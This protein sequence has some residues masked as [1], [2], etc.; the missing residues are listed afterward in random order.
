MKVIAVTCGGASPNRKL[1]RMHWH[2]IQDNDMNPET[3]VLI[4][5]VIYLAVSKTDSFTLFLMFHSHLLKTA[6][7]CL[8]SSRSGKFTCYTWNGSMFL[9]WNHIADILY[10][11][12]EC[13]LHILQNYA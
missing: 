9:L 8:S 12:Q 11:D 10:E 13:G 3:D 4:T 2:S 5:H 7:N 6:R 1:F